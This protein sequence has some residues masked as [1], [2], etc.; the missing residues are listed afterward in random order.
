MPARL[1][2]QQ[3]NGIIFFYTL[4]MTFLCTN[5]NVLQFPVPLL[6]SRG[7]GV[8]WELLFM[9]GS[10]I[11]SFLILFLMEFR[12]IPLLVFKIRQKLK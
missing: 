11:L 1:G 6:S 4:C 12:L 7:F 2:K 5:K 9:T 3:G 10:G 8:F